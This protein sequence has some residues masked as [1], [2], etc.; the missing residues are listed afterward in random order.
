MT[1]A[2]M[3]RPAAA[4]GRPEHLAVGR[5]AG[6]LVVSAAEFLATLGEA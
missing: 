4:E 1:R 6:V 5:F 2:A 3:A